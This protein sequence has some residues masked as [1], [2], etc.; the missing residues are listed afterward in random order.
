[1]LLTLGNPLLWGFAIIG[2]NEIFAVTAMAGSALLLQRKRWAWSGAIFALAIASKQIAWVVTPLWLWWVW[3]SARASS[4]MWPNLKRALL[5]LVSVGGVIFLPFLLWGPTKLFTDL[6]KFA[7]GGFANSYPTAGTTFLQYLYVYHII[8]SP[9]TVY[10]VYLFQLFVGVPV[11]ILV[12]SWLRQQHQASR[13]LAGS[14]VLLLAVMLVSKYFNNNFLTAPAGLLVA[15][16]V[17][18]F[19]EQSDA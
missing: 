12:A 1:M 2:C 17:L 4:Q 13:W 11:F 5:G 10:P 18:Q 14:A 9:Y 8:P 7:G 16:F 6:V 15:A 3:Q 19:H